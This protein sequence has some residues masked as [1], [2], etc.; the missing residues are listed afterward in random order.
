MSVL[1]PDRTHSHES[2]LSQDL[3]QQFFE[4]GYCI[5][6]GLLTR[7]EVTRT[8]KALEN[9]LARAG[10]LAELQ[11]ADFDGETTDEGARFV[12]NTDSK[13][14]LQQLHRV[15]GCGSADPLLL[16]VSRHPSL[17]K[18]FADLL[19]SSSF[20]QIICQ[21]HPKLPG[22][23][24]TFRPHRDV[25]FRLLC[26][27]GWQDINHWGSYA[28]AVMAIDPASAENG[29]LCLVPGSHHGVD[30]SRIQPASTH[31]DPDWNRQMIQPELA[32]GDVLFMHPYMVH[33]S[34][35]N[36]GSNTRF[37]LLSGVCSP[38]A[39]HR[40]YPGDCTNQM[41]STG[42]LSPEQKG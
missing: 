26:D 16:K 33:W 28:V 6:P 30:L 12:F 41:L 23:D 15:C 1:L 22:D 34:G 14:Q 10:Q 11:G 5:L 31:F 27:S 21:F 4:Q 37:S 32:A 7:K 24:V 9:L 19:M 3:W 25:E 13:G 17:L 39:N 42:S 40:N 29:G 35:A 8:R 18:A 38:G 36:Q 2:P 20:E